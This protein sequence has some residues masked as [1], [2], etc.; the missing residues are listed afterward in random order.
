MRYL[1]IA[2]AFAGLMC[3]SVAAFGQQCP[4]GS[5]PFVNNEAKQS[6]KALDSGRTTTS[7]PSSKVCPTGTVA[8]VDNQGKQVCRKT[9]VQPSND[10]SK[11]C[12]VG[13]YPTFDKS[14]K[15]V[16]RRA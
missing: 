5:Y 14:G 12:P 4:P 15:P 11:P 13:T 3:V 9:N 7:E 2:T 10:P 6:C 8:V 1:T 16:C